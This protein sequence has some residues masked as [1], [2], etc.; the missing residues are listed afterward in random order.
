MSDRSQ[1]VLVHAAAGSLVHSSLMVDGSG[2]LDGVRV[3]A[4]QEALAT[5]E[6]SS[7]ATSSL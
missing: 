6:R 2:D 3:P 5:I 1:A 7:M 4:D